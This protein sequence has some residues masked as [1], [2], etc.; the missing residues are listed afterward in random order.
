[1][2]YSD[3]TSEVKTHMPLALLLGDILPVTLLVLDVAMP[4]TLLILGVAMRLTYCF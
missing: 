2:P 3:I 1:M 4:L